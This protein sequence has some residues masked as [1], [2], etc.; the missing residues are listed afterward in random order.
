MQ[1]LGLYGGE[2]LYHF[3]ERN[4]EFPLH[5]TEAI[6]VYPTSRQFQVITQTKPIHMYPPSRTYDGIT[7]TQPIHS[8]PPYR[9]YDVIS[10]ATIYNSLILFFT[11][12]VLQ[13]NYTFCPPMST[14]T[15]SSCSSSSSSIFQNLTS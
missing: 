4:T 5:Q 11:S 14:N 13:D 3:L 2:D 1:D 8:Y 12:A 6:Y 15:S 10:Q 7:Q 9:L